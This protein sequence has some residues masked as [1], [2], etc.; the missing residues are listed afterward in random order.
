MKKALSVMLTVL[1]VI[2]LFAGCSKSVPEYEFTESE[3]AKLTGNISVVSFN[4]ASPWGSRFGDTSSAK[5]VK[6]FAAYMNAVK[7]ASIGTQEM[8]RKWIEKLKELMPE[9]SC[10]A[11]DR[12]GDD[13]E[14]KS[15]TNAVFYNSTDFELV[16]A[17]TFWLSQTPGKESR[18]ENAG[19]NRICSY[20]VL[21][22]KLTGTSYIHMNTH[23][24][25]ASNEAK[26]FG[27]NVIN[28]KL[29]DIYKEYGYLPVVL[30]GDLNDTVGSIPWK[31]LTGKG[32][33]DSAD[34]AGGKLKSTYTDWGK[35]EDNGQP[36]DFIFGMEQ[37]A[38]EYRVLDDISGGCVSDHYGVYAIYYIGDGEE[39]TQQ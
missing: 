8:N 18:Y 5:R 26:V 27:A 4:V 28:D 25:N 9:Y 33:V 17:G 12:G 6:R 34:E 38:V 29:G 2:S 16:N 19:C 14:N 21:K 24:D 13:S 31:T 32:W 39:G 36:I 15:E 37:R 35:L 11:V 23:L 10:Y 22:N 20:V 3:L 30:T 1:L 7:P